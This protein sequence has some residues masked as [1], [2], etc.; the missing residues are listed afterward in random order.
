MLKKSEYS[1]H[2]YQVKY[3]VLEKIR[4]LI[5]Q[6]KELEKAIHQRKQNDKSPTEWSNPH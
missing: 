3:V 4:L 6:E 1:I 2:L 5:T